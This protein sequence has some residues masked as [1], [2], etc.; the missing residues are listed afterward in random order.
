[1]TNERPDLCS[2]CGECCRTRPGAEAPDRF[3]GAADP[4]GALAGA[5]ASGDWVVARHAGMAWE[6]GEPPPGADRW[7]TIRYPR[8]ATVR[9][10]GTLVA[11]A[12]ADASP[13]V[14]LDPGGCRLPFEGRPRMCRELE[15][16]ANGECVAAWDLP[17]AARAWGPW[18]GLIDDAL[19]RIS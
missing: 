13:C 9:E 14:Y 16:W 15:P 7:R 4:A 18:Q 1:M 8:P 10:R 3:L 17:Q 11:D 12:G 19:R 5:L 6:G 2:T